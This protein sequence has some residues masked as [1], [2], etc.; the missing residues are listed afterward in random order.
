MLFNNVLRL[1]MRSFFQET[2]CNGGGVL[3]G[4]VIYASGEGAVCISARPF[5]E[6]NDYLAWRGDAHEANAAADVAGQ[7]NGF[8]QNGVVVVIIQTVQGLQVT[9]IVGRQ[10]E[11]ADVDGVGTI[12][13][14]VGNAVESSGCKV[15][16]EA[17]V[18][19]ERG[20]TVAETVVGEDVV[21]VL[22][23]G[24]HQVVLIFL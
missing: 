1:N 14:A 8:H 21:L 23:A 2:V 16:V 3:Q 13:L 10:V 5:G 18:Y 9:V 4:F 20:R 17:G 11:Q 12:C 19:L 24:K 6:G 15:I 22:D 7:G